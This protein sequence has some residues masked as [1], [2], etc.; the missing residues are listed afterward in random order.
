MHVYAWNVGHYWICCSSSCFHLQLWCYSSTWHGD[1]ASDNDARVN[2][3]R[4]TLLQSCLYASFGGKRISRKK[5]ITQSVLYAWKTTSMMTHCARYH[6]GTNSTRP[7]WMHGSQHT[8]NLQVLEEV[9][10]IYALLITRWSTASVPFANTT[11]A[12]NFLK[13]LMNV[14]PF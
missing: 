6:A 10:C 3:H 8:R 4:R 5:M 7:A 12:A 9:L 14:H 13:A 11:F 2:L 1:C